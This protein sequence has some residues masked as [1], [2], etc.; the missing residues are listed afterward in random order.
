MLF[1]YHSVS[2][3]RWIRMILPR[4]KLLIA[5]LVT[6]TAATVLVLCDCAVFAALVVALA[7]EVIRVTAGTEWSVA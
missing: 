5:N 4:S 2:I 1:R 3:A 7:F 6:T